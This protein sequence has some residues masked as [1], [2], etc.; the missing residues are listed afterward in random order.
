MKAFISLIGSLIGLVC[1]F[2]V[3]HEAYGTFKVAV[4]H[5][6]P[7]AVVQTHEFN[8]LEW[9]TSSGYGLTTFA[10]ESVC[11]VIFSVMGIGGGAMIL[12]VTSGPG[13]VSTT[14]TSLPASDSQIQDGMFAMGMMLFLYVIFRIV[15]ACLGYSWPSAFWVFIWH[16][17]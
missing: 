2:M 4:L 15:M 5:Q 7:A 10:F 16:L 12:S 17:L 3:L 11:M 1:V 9:H 6:K 8:P 13:G 14:T